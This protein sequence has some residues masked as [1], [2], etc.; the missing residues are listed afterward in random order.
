MLYVACPTQFH[1]WCMY[2]LLFFRS[3][4]FFVGIWNVLLILRMTIYMNHHKAKKSKVHLQE[5]SLYFS[6]HVFFPEM[7]LFDKQK[8]RFFRAT[9]RALSNICRETRMSLSKIRPGLPQ[10]WRIPGGEIVEFSEVLV[11]VCS[12]CASLVKFAA[13]SVRASFLFLA[14]GDYICYKEPWMCRSNK[15]F[16]FLSERQQTYSTCNSYW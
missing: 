6:F 9:D 5:R 13:H 4:E 15:L 16:H 11:S 14:D 10:N 2:L 3:A 1:V 7:I 8:I 12:D